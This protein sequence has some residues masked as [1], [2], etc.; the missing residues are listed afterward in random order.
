MVIKHEFEIDGPISNKRPKIA[1]NVG[2]SSSEEEEED[3]KEFQNENIQKSNEINEDVDF[4]DSSSSL[5]NEKE[6]CEFNEIQL[7]FIS[8]LKSQNIGIYSSFDLE[9][10]SISK[11][12]NFNQCEILIPKSEME[13][14]FENYL[15]G[16]II[17]LNA[18]KNKNELIFISPL[19]SFINFLIK[20]NEKFP[21]SFTD[22]NRKQRNN[23]IYKN[24]SL[25]LKTKSLVY[26]KWIKF[27]NLS[28]IE[29]TSILNNLKL[30][31]N[32]NIESIDSI[33][34]LF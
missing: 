2:Y 15:K 24:L 33:E 11:S 14:I 1:L 13:S 32:E 18:N 8:I 20:F 23:Q 28:P 22:F 16:K 9:F 6:E 34:L 4:S 19:K 17:E 26:N 30:K 5:N 3:E 25:D 29:K 31:F 7:K 27:K 10:D 21:N 12:P